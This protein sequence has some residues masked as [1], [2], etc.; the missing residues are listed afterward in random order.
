MNET[1]FMQVTVDAGLRAGFQAAAA[2]QQQPAAQ[3]LQALMRDYVL[4]HAPPAPAGESIGNEQD[5]DALVRR[6]Q[7]WHCCPFGTG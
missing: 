4:L 2:C 1:V 3:V 6:Q 7:G 5:L